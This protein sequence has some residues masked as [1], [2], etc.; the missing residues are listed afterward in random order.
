MDLD[1][2][3]KLADC[4]KLPHDLQLQ[5]WATGDRWVRSS[6][7]KR[8]DLETTIE[9]QCVLDDSLIPAWAS[10][11]GRSPVVLDIA[12]ASAHTEHALMS[13]SSQE[14][15]TSEGLRRLADKATPMVGWALLTR[16]DLTDEQRA[17][18]AVRYVVFS[19]LGRN[20]FGK[21]IM[22]RL[23]TVP[24]VWVQL[25]DAISW[26]QIGVL[27]AASGSLSENESVREAFI[28]AVER[29][30][31]TA[32]G[33]VAG[34][35][36][37]APD[38]GYTANDSPLRTLLSSVRQLLR[39]PNVPIDQLERLA[40]VQVLSAVRSDLEKRAT[41]RIAEVVA[42]LQREPDGVTESCDPAEGFIHVAL[43]RSLLANATDV[44]VPATVLL[45]EALHHRDLLTT[46]EIRRAC[47]LVRGPES[48]R[49]AV[50][51]EEL[52]RF[53]DL[54]EFAKRGSL[55]VLDQVRDQERVLVR[56][57]SEG[58]R[59][60]LRARLDDHR[61]RLVIGAYR[62]LR[63]VLAESRLVEFLLEDL[64]GLDPCS[65][66]TALGLLGGWEGSISELMLASVSLTGAGGG[67][68]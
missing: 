10:V 29:L 46:D 16:G 39:S 62:P 61:T 44:T 11:A 12:V 36:P 38:E 41:L 21:D 35:D 34:Y 51:L 54:V 28:A 42:M 55:L 6:L 48:R 52:G 9:S 56:L 59:D 53:D 18:L 19:D 7:V 30:D 20:S 57:A 3:R 27:H 31:A 32:E 40:C 22:E 66:E 8:A 15:L 45:N 4:P 37:S 2:A 49:V 60:V 67:A 17:E 50:R 43:L 63:E 64:Y 68:R 47:D 23:G 58:C 25:L 5:L 24:A 26:R 33:V 65:R 1:I 14:L 13:I